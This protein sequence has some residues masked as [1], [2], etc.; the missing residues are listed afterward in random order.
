MKKCEDNC[1]LYGFKDNMSYYNSM[2]YIYK[3]HAKKYLDDGDAELFK[4]CPYCG[5]KLDWEEIERA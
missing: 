1:C 2:D 3:E 5:N 4:Y